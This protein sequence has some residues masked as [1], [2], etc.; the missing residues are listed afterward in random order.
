M[1]TGPAEGKFHLYLL[2]TKMQVL[3][4]LPFPYSAVGTG[5]LRWY[6]LEVPSI[7]VPKQFAVGL[8]FRPDAG[9]AIHL[10]LNRGV[11]TTHSFVGLPATGYQKMAQP[12]EW[13]VRV[14]VSEKPAGKME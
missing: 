13:M 2:G 9:R 3:A 11:E 10:G 14:V 12:V 5:E 6:D 4:D 1:R 8:D 7:E